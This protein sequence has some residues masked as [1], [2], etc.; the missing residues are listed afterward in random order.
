MGARGAAVTAPLIIAAA[1]C[2]SWAAVGLLA[3]VAHRREA[4]ARSAAEAELCVTRTTLVRVLN[5]ASR[6]ALRV[7]RVGGEYRITEVLSREGAAIYAEG[8]E[9]WP[10]PNLD[11]GNLIPRPKDS[12]R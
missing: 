7:E 10:R 11:I 8:W 6:D 4:R 5:A 12:P 3:V 1:L 2:V 9:T